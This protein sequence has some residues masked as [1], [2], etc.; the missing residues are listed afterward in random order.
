[1]KKQI[2]IAD[3]MDIDSLQKLQD[4]FSHTT[5]LSSMT[6]DVY[7]NS[8]TRSS[9][10]RDFCMKCNM[11]SALGRKRCKECHQKA[12]EYVLR[13]HKPCTYHCHCGL[14]NYAVAIVADGKALGA[15]LGG[16][17]FD[18]K[19]DLS[20]IRKIAVE[21]GIDPDIYVEAAKEVPVIGKGGM[22]KVTE[23]L[24]DMTVTFST[25]SY[26]ALEINKMN[27][28]IAREAS[29]KSDFLANMSHE[30]RTPMNA[31]SGLVE[32]ALRE[33]ISPE[34]KDYLNK[35]KNS[36]QSLLVIINDILDYSK[37][38][39]GKFEIIDTSYD[40]L[41]NTDKCMDVVYSKFADK[42]VEYT[43]DFSPDIPKTLYADP[44]RVNQILTN[45]MTNAI[46]F[47]KSGEIHYKAECIPGENDETVILRV[48]ITDTGIGIK[49]NNLESIFN[50]FQQVDSKRNRNIEGTGLGLAISRQLAELMGGKLYVE[51][52]YG[53]GSTFTV[54]IPHR[55]IDRSPSIPCV[56]KNLSV[57]I[58]IG[59]EYVKKQLVTD[60]ERVELKY[61]ELE[62]PDISSDPDFDFLII[63]DELY[64]QSINDIL[65]R[66]P[67]MKC[68]Y[69][70]SS[71]KPDIIDN[72]QII[73]IHKPLYS[74]NL[75]NA[76]GITDT[77]FRASDT[78]ID[79][80][81]FTAP[82]AKVLIVDDNKIN[83]TVAKGL[84]EPLNMHTDLAESAAE[85]IA[86]VK[87]NK[88]DIIF[89]DHMMP[90]VDGIECTHI[91]RRMFPD[92]DNIPIIALTANAVGGV[93]EM[94]IQ[95]GMN[96]FIPK[97]IEIVTI[98]SKIRSWLPQEKIILLKSSDN[99][100][101]I[102]ENKDIESLN[103]KGLN[104]RA[105]LALTGNNELY[106][107][108][109]K[110]YY[111]SID[112]KSKLILKYQ[113]NRQWKEYTIEVHT[114][115]SISKQIGADDLSELAAQL[116][117]AGNN[118]YYDFISKKTPELIDK[119]IQYKEILAPVFPDVKPAIEKEATSAKIICLIDEMEMAL[120][121]FDILHIDDVIQ[122]MKSYR[123]PDAQM[124][125]FE[126]LQK[127][128]DIS[129][130][131][132]CQKIIRMWKNV[133][134]TPLDKNNIM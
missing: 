125:Y 88:Y 59:N 25:M 7:G 13:S 18:E 5:G 20:K 19:P 66:T 35:I 84:I 113:Q 97:P 26:Q 2:S 99:S 82:E 124:K 114:L 52:T 12:T 76:L 53:K 37:I 72:T 74:L 108:I 68:I 112:K 6:A 21:L 62:N 85:A 31:I 41:E 93:K 16:A 86:L 67:S 116:E 4:S 126:E 45:I 111:T 54:E 30:I 81:T 10:V 121:N 71:D 34:V 28:E 43:V 119:Y 61:Q 105:A 129:N 122:E 11:G 90:E 24:T 48:S 14:V 15:F 98:V 57:G 33:V 133:V 40:F 50:S 60:L 73:V 1:M 127:N 38:E 96:D 80:F 51:S 106:M 55:I 102:K 49:K 101:K 9:N 91:I 107:T 123:Y 103:I 131:E 17:T 46:K 75:Y 130:L 23:F 95:E 94:F 70:T 115:K 39:S 134:E 58:F 36:A 78:T 100:S 27:K 42:P 109:L 83:L 63:E 110:E 8:I 47:T 79:Y 77:V 87:K 118:S 64:T 92:Y 117:S 69:V 120:S 22:K 56:K 65:N 132:K 29:L 89:M 104:T 128:V 3:L 32:L 44:I